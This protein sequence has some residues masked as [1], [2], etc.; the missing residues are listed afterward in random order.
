PAWQQVRKQNVDSAMA[1]NEAVVS[2]KTAGAFH[3]GELFRLHLGT[4]LGAANPEKQAEEVP[5]AQNLFLAAFGAVRCDK[6]ADHTLD[7]QRG[8]VVALGRSRTE[9]PDG[10][11]LPALKN[12]WLELVKEHFLPALFHDITWVA[13]TDRVGKRLVARAEERQGSLE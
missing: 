6:T 7:Q 3:L 9:D 13:E 5:L 12:T 4:A 2:S 10:V 8:P 11:A 1:T